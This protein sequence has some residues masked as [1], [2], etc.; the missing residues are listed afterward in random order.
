MMSP[1]CHDLAV[2]LRLPLKTLESGALSSVWR[3][4]ESGALSL[5]RRLR[6]S[7][8]HSMET[9]WVLVG[10]HSVMN[11][12]A[13]YKVVSFSLRQLYCNDLG[14]W[15]TYCEIRIIQLEEGSLS[16]Q[17]STQQHAILFFRIINC[18]NIQQVYLITECIIAVSLTISLRPLSV[19]DAT[20][21]IFIM[22]LWWWNKVG[23]VK[24]THLK[25]QSTKQPCSSQWKIS[26]TLEQNTSGAIYGFSLSM[27]HSQKYKFW[28]KI[29]TIES[30]PLIKKI[31]KLHPKYFVPLLD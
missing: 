16:T 5:V 1:L 2:R 29:W 31:H 24:R 30:A 14:C 19:T 9:P 22:G 18:L 3:T 6:C 11:R 10:N 23:Q 15:W 8:R 26:P 17:Y 20:L 13:V 4:L 21:Y 25:S 28:L 12:E 27:E 7:T